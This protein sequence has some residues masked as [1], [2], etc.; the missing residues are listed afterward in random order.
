MKKTSL[1][2]LEYLDISPAINAM[3]VPNTPFLSY[4]LGA[5]KQS[6]QTR[7]KLNGVN[8]ISTTMILLKNLRAE[9]IQMLNQVEL[10][11]TTILKFLENQPLYLVH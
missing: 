8:M 4:L 5:G 3:Q 11:L 9:N 6:Q 1:N 7:Q 2:N 10:G